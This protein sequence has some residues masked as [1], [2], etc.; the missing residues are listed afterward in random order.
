[1]TKLLEYASE[2]SADPFHIFNI[3]TRFYAL[4]CLAV[5]T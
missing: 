5:D 2:N 3:E 1:M 4:N